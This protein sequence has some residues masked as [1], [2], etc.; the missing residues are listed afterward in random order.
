MKNREVPG[1]VVANRLTMDGGLEVICLS[2]PNTEPMS[3]LPRNT[4]T[5]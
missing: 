5:T 4:L 1:M 3:T 2:A